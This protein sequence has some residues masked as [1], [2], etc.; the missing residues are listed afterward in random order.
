MS[1]DTS[2]AAAVR[3]ADASTSPTKKKFSHHKRHGGSARKLRHASSGGSSTDVNLVGAKQQP[4]RR[5]GA[6]LLQQQQQLQDQKNPA[7]P[8]QYT[9]SSDDDHLHL[10]HNL[11]SKRVPLLGLH[12]Q[13]TFSDDNPDAAF[14]SSAQDKDAKRTRNN[15]ADTAT[16]E[17][18]GDESDPAQLV[19]KAA[20]YR[21]AQS[22]VAG[23][24]GG[25]GHPKLSRLMSCDAGSGNRSSNNDESAEESGGIGG[26]SGLSRFARGLSTKTRRR[27]VAASTREY[28]SIT[29]EL[30]CLMPEPR[31]DPSPTPPPPPA[32]MIQTETLHDAEEADFNLMESLIERRLR[33]DSH[34]LQASLE[35]LVTKSIRDAASSDESAEALDMPSSA[36]PPSKG[37]LQQP[38]MFGGGS[39]LSAGDISIQVPVL[40]RKGVSSLSPSPSLARHGDGSGGVRVRLAATGTDSTDQRVEVEY[41]DEHTKP[42]SC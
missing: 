25:A 14:Y 41:I 13:R 16:T 21:R 30:E 2:A 38:P 28:T 9:E 34:N 5:K 37:I 12:T 15:T 7:R 39:S 32:I 42:T 20:L 26:G 11:V 35:E 24:G 27:I 3:M 40:P 18:D 6:K 29:D 33:R 4:R 31:P 8:R 22:E 17:K 19:D 1:E 36:P 23:S 10:H